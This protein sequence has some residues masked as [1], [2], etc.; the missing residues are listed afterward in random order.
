MLLHTEAL[1][2]NGGKATDTRSVE[3]GQLRAPGSNDRER[4]HHRA[5]EGS[6][7]EDQRG[8]RPD[9]SRASISADARA[10][11]A[12]GAL[13]AT[14]TVPTVSTVSCSSTTSRCR[15]SSISLVPV[16]GGLQ[17]S[18]EIDGLDVP[19]HMSYAVACL[20][21]TD[22]TDIKATK[23]VVS[24]ILAV[25]PDGMNGF[26]TDLA[27]PGVQLTGLD[28][29]LGRRPRRHPRHPPARQ[30]D[31]IHPAQGRGHGHEADDEPSARRPRRPEDAQ[32]PRQERS[33][34]RSRRRPSCS[35]RAARSSRST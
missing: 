34:F 31:R 21:G 17:F 18:A 10:D 24:G 28:I 2:A 29:T 35:A 4:G 19:G 25:T 22:T 33:P 7:R 14:R 20:G 3:A 8:R 26:N 12:D 15:T 16:A 11:A 9:R 32:R 1:D 6:V 13:A 23:V 5:V 27:E 30:R